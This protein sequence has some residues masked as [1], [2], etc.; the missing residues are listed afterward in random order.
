MIITQIRKGVKAYFDSYNYN[1]LCRISQRSFQ[2]RRCCFPRKKGALREKS[3]HVPPRTGSDWPLIDQS[4][5]VRVL[6]GSVLPDP[7]HLDPADALHQREALLIGHTKQ[8]RRKRVRKRT[9]LHKHR[10]R[11]KIGGRHTGFGI[12][13]MVIPLISR[14]KIPLIVTGGHK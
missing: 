2:N 6:H 11:R 9:V 13:D 8:C 7:K 14:H 4:H 3:R 1:N 5:T 12:D 10:D